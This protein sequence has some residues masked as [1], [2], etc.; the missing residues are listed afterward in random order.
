M[1]KWI[2][3][4]Q[5]GFTLVELLVAIPIIALIGMA[6]GAVIIQLM[7]ANNITYGISAIRQVQTAGDWVSRDGLQFQEVTSGVASDNV[8][9]GLPFT[10]K[11]S[12]WDADASPPSSSIHEVTYSLLAMPNGGS[13]KQLQRHEV[14]KDSD[15]AT[16]SDT[17]II[18]ARYID[19]SA[20]ATSC[21]WVLEPL[22]AP[23][24][25]ET[26]FIFTVTSVMGPKTESRTYRVMGRAAG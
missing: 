3:G 24:Y 23:H 20:T 1:M 16:I 13:L 9:L 7:H 11:W 21:R 6:A 14:V 5:R 15:N 17:A 18:V 2:K 4:K 22:P 8:S 10:L 26:T 12:Y 19:A 25:S